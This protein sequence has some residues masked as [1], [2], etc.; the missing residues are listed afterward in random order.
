[1]QKNQLI[2][3]EDDDAS[4]LRM[5]T[6]SMSAAG[7]QVAPFGSAEGLL[8]SGQ[9]SKAACIILDMDLPGLSGLELQQ[10]L[11]LTG[12]DVPIIFISGQATE[13]KR[14]RAL[15]DGAIA[16]FDKPFDINALLTAVRSA[17][18]TMTFA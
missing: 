6:R 13:K 16:F 8:I 18:V 12:R 9:M 17:V 2:C 5:L 10:R 7:F 1:M 15:M 14:H 11:K 3:G 4:M